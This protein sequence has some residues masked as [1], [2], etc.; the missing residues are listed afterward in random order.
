VQQIGYILVVEPDDLIRTL[1]DGWLSEAGYSVVAAS[2]STPA[3]SEAPRL[4]IANLSSPGSASVALR[5][6]QDAYD[7]PILALSARIRRSQGT[8]KDLA[9]QLGVCNVLAKPFTRDELLAAVRECL[10]ARRKTEG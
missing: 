10:G 8:S 4:V 3:M 2:R 9:R 6:L 5:S 7:A 1:L